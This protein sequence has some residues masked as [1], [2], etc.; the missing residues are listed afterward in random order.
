MATTAMPDIANY[1]IPALA[2]GAV[3]PPNREFLAVLG[4]QTS[5]TNIEAPEGLIR[6]L[7]QEELGDTATLLR[8]I[9]AAVK[10]GHVIM[11]DGT[12]FGRTA[13]KTINSIT[14]TA[15]KQQLIL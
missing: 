6:Q 12:V 10:A 7:L 9:L 14:T 2:Q 1:N 11:V 8:E 13:I 5:G 4:D 3:I 15:G